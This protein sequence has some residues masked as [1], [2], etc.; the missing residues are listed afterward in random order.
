MVSIR[1]IVGR[2][3]CL[4]KVCTV[5]GTLMEGMGTEATLEE[6]TMLVEVVTETVGMDVAMTCTFMF[7]LVCIL[8]CAPPSLAPPGGGGGGHQ[9][10][11]QTGPHQR[12]HPTGQHQGVRPLPTARRLSDLSS[13]AQLILGAL[14]VTGTRI[15]HAV[16][17]WMGVHLIIMLSWSVIP[18][19][20]SPPPL[21]VDAL[22]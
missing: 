8:A 6:D 19:P 12:V 16:A 9:A 21:A 10:V 15:I 7:T 3:E 2:V 18:P 1:R 22:R 5:T 14:R 4:M 20:M 11:P 17:Q 13:V